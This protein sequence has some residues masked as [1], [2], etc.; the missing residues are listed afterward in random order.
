MAKIE[1]LIGRCYEAD[2]G[3]TI[4]A[5]EKRCFSALD[6]EDTDDLVPEKEDYSDMETEELCEIIGQMISEINKGAD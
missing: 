4:T 2:D 1:C 5:A 6:D 3:S